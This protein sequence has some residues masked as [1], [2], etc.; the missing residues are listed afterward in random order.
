V[1]RRED[2][3]QQRRLARARDE[4]KSIALLLAGVAVG[5]GGSAVTSPTAPAPVPPPLFGSPFPPGT[6]SGPD[7]VT[8]VVTETTTQSPRPVSGVS[9]SAW[10]DLG[11]MAYSYQWANGRRTTDASG[12]YELTNLPDGANVTLQIWKDGYVQQCA[13]PTFT[14]SGT[15][16]LD[17]RL[18]SRALVSADRAS[19][20][21]PAPG[22]R[23]VS[24]VV[25]DNTPD[26]KRPVPGAPVDFEPFEDFPAAVTYSDAQGR[27]L[28]CGLP[29]G[30]AATLSASLTTARVAYITVPPHQTAIDIELPGA[31]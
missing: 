26:G 29:D 19:V 14:T 21:A 9:V 13:A 6:T 2:G 5:C 28:L 1:G 25:Y 16:T 10:V 20:P 30:T 17:L 15:T 11:R 27:Y 4:V 22:F 31:R 24:G 3:V 7:S 18:V 23:H 12:R 8:G